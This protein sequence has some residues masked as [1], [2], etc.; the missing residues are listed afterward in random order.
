MLLICVDSL[1]NVVLAPLSI[2]LRDEGVYAESE[3]GTLMKTK[4]LR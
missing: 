4:A 3:A 2:K 1:T